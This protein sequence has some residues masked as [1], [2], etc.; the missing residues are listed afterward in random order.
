M[1]W[2][3]KVQQMMERMRSY[4]KREKQQQFKQKLNRNE[5]FMV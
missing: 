3:K 2:K 5:L 4:T 1:V